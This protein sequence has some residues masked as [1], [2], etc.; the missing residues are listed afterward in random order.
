MRTPRRV[1]F[2]RSVALFIVLALGLKWVVSRLVAP[3][4]SAAL[5][6]IGMATPALAAAVVYCLVERKALFSDGV[7][8][9]IWGTR[10]AIIAGGIALVLALQA[11]VFC[12]IVITVPHSLSLATIQHALSTG[13]LRG[14][15][16]PAAIMIAVML[17]VTVG[18]LLGVIPCLGEEIGWR[19]FLYPRLESM[20]GYV[21]AVVIGGIIWSF[22]HS[23]EFV[24]LRD[25]DGYGLP[26]WLGCAYFAL[27]TIP[28][29]IV[30][31]WLYRRSGSILAPAMAHAAMDTSYNLMG[32]FLSGAKLTALLT[33]PAGAIG[34][35]VWWPPAVIIVWNYWRRNSSND[36][37]VW[38]RVARKH[39]G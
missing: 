29:G 8:R 22:W 5:F 36:R 25:F 2:R 1:V 10:P 13:H 7:R 39:A 35:I 3:A 32:V 38:R 18:V 24:F 14:L 20:I 33:N 30:L 15:G 4:H 11:I 16:L 9:R 19:A 26:W 27:F 17:N 6:Y 37:N 21:P 31:Y 34:M 23:P 28:G 12:A